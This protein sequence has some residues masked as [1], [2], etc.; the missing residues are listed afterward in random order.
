MS[1]AV[2][3]ALMLVL[4]S[5]A[6]GLSADVTA[7]RD[8]KQLAREYDN[9]HGSSVDSSCL[10]YFNAICGGNRWVALVGSVLVYLIGGAGS[11]ALLA[12]LQGRRRARH[13]TTEARRTEHR[14]K[15]D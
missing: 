8:F 10:P 5:C 15:H 7:V 1:G 2:H 11:R 14:Q 3:G 6:A 12:A 4:A 9:N 13:A